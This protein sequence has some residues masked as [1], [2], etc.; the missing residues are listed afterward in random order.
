MTEEG[1]VANAKK[2]IADSRGIGLSLHARPFQAVMITKADLHC[3]SQLKPECCAEHHPAWTWVKT[4][5]AA[6]QGKDRVA[7]LIGIPC[8]GCWPT[9]GRPLH[10]VVQLQMGLFVLFSSG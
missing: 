6:W 4:A 8:S 7:I 2:C 5:G 1:A 9:H 10:L 3:T